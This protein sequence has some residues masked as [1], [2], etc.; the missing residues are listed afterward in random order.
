MT[1]PANIF[2]EDIEPG[3]VLETGSVTLNAT[4]IRIFAEKFDPQPYHLDREAADASLFGGLCASGWHV[5]ALMMKLVSDALASEHIPLIGSGEVSWL[6]WYRPAFDGDCLSAHV[7]ISGKSRP[8]N[9]NEDETDHGLI[10]CD[11]TVHNQNEKK[12]MAVSTF[13]MIARKGAANV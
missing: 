9:E 8:E 2:W 10:E 6:E 5:S 4:D 12:V 1:T 11:I 3:R 13:L 7:T